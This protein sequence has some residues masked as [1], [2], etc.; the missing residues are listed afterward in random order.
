MKVKLRDGIKRWHFNDWSIKRG[1]VK[2][3][4]REVFEISNGRLEIV[5]TSKKK[6]IKKT[7]EKTNT[8]DNEVVEKLVEL[9]EDE[10]QVR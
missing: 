1:E 5:K 6:K 7:D 8:D 9:N 10:I 2:E 3:C 4:P